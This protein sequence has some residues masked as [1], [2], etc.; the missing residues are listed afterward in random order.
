MA[1]NAADNSD[2][3]SRDGKHCSDTPT[4]KRLSKPRTRRATL[5][6]TGRRNEHWDLVRS[7]KE[8]EGSTREAYEHWIET[9]GQS[10]VPR[11]EANTRN[12]HVSP[13][14]GEPNRAGGSR[15]V[16]AGSM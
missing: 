5:S 9:G 12:P 1:I 15:A 13:H 16:F 11:G 4:L 6:V 2:A 7:R 3:D 10:A 8:A 14:D